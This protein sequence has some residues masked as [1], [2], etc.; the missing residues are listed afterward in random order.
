M[1]R[2]N[3][4]GMDLISYK[5]ELMKDYPK[6]VR[7][8]L[9]LAIE[10]LAS[11]QV[12]DAD[13]FGLIKND[14]VGAT[15]FK[16]YIEAST[17]YMKTEEEILLE[18]KK[19]EDQLKEIISAKELQNVKTSIVTKQDVVMINRGFIFNEEFVREFFD[20][21]D[22]KD[23][24][25]LMKRRGF[26]EKFAVLRLNAIFKPFLLRAKEE[27]PEVV[28]DLSYVFFDVEEEGYKMDIFFA[29][30]E[31]MFD[32]IETLNT[33]VDKVKDIVEKAEVEFKNKTLI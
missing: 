15:E 30:K 33:Y 4:L 23:M 13:A 12:I 24:L 17:M 2:I 25:D 7:D 16:R 5:E 9:M 19:L 1:N 28:V 6:I 22:E 18:F 20:V 11:T 8:S 29:I 31:E 26:V 3:K 27:H 21:E 32:D 10:Q 14:G